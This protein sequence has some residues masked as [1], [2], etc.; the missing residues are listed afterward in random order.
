MLQ[1][2]IAA[3]DLALRY[4][5]QATALH[6]LGAHWQIFQEVNWHLNLREL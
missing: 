5:A 6:F 2:L 1:S 4:Q 3:L